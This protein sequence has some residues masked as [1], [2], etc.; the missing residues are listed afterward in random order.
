MQLFH[1]HL[2][3]AGFAAMDDISNEGRYSKR[4]VGFPDKVVSVVL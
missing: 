4:I 3:R 2:W 1:D